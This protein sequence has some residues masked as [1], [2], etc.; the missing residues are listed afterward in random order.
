MAAGVR[1]NGPAWEWRAV[2]EDL[3]TTELVQRDLRLDSHTDMQTTTSR[4]RTPENTLSHTASVNHT[5]KTRRSQHSQERNYPR[6]HCFCDSRPWPVDTKINRFPGLIVELLSVRFGD[7]SWVSFSDI[8]QKKQTDRQMASAWV[9]AGKLKGSV[10][11]PDNFHFYSFGKTQ[12]KFSIVE[13]AIFV[14]NIWKN[15]QI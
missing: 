4:H 6:R 2:A 14:T 13:K 1:W 9:I 15:T 3:L 7:T 8:V 10:Q 12:L 11:Q 5:V